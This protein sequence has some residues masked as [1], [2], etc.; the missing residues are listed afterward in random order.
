MI[1][2]GLYA[3]RSGQA[4]NSGEL[5][6]MAHT[7]SSG[8]PLVIAAAGAMAAALFGLR[9]PG[10]SRYGGVASTPS[11]ALLVA[12]AGLLWAG[13]ARLIELLGVAGPWGLYSGPGL[14]AFVVGVAVA[15]LKMRGGGGTS[16]GGLLIAIAV[17]RSL[18]G[19]VSMAL[20]NLLGRDV[21]ANLAATRAGHAIRLLEALCWLTLAAIFARGGMVRMSAHRAS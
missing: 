2:A 19:I 11:T 4:L 12:G 18:T 20:F 7:V 5:D 8:Q 15:G 16:L 21:A 14:L 13:T 17:L 6:H 10:V 1:A 9:I 3:A